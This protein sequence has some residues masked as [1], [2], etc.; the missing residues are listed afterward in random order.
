MRLRS[1]QDEHGMKPGPSISRIYLVS[2]TQT[3]VLTGLLGQLDNLLTPVLEPVVCTELPCIC[4]TALSLPLTRLF[5]SALQLHS[6]DSSHST[7]ILTES[8][9]P[10]NKPRNRGFSAH[11]VDLG[12][13]G[14]MLH[15]ACL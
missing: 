12:F 5:R 11:H 6:S 1:Q 14:E 9:A 10:P 8:F 2:T 15:R 3:A 4:F 7:V 13:L